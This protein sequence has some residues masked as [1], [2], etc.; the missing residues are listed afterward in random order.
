MKFYKLCMNERTYNKQLKKRKQELK[1][2][3]I[4]IDEFVLKIIK[5]RKEL[6]EKVRKY[7]QVSKYKNDWESKKLLKQL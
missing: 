4:S 3:K 5:K 6:K 1:K 7:F 2:I